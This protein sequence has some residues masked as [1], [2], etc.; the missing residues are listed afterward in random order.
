LIDER[1]KAEGRRRKKDF[2]LH[3]SS[4]ILYKTGDFA[5][6]LPDGTLL[7][8]GRIDDQVKI[9]GVRMELGEVETALRALPG[10]RDAVVTAWRD[11]R[12]DMQL[13]GHIIA[14]TTPAPSAAE[15]RAQLRDRLPEVMIPPYFLFSEAFPLTANGKIRRAALPTPDVIQSDS[16]TPL[17]MPETPSEQLLAQAWARV[18]G[19]ELTRIGRDSDFIDLGGHSLLMTPLMLEVRKLFGVSF[20]LRE[21]F[22]ASTLRAL[23]ALIDERS[24]EMSKDRHDRVRRTSGPNRTPEWGRQRMAFLLREAQLPGSLYPARGMTYQPGEINKVFMTG[25]TGFLGVYLIAEILRTTRAHLYCLARPKRGEDSK[26]RIEKQM[27]RY[28][29]WRKDAPWLA[30]WDTRL[31]VVEGDVTLPRL[32]MADSAYEM[33]A[34]EVDAI[35]HSAAHVNFIYPYEALRATNVLGLHEIIRFAFY[36]RIKP[37]HHLSTAA[38][39]PMGAQYTYYEKDPIDHVG[40]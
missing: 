37:V 16:K 25:G 18:L 11:T 14:A 22:S 29:V 1:M 7:C 20:N 12:G 28:D 36:A 32:G 39:W 3:P 30:D 23:T 2:I 21:F 10:I 17:E 35:L 24:N 33:L 8:L 6:Y 26:S 27:H 13:V 34:R 19:I 9:H 40:V 31:H 4:L 5:R 15:L 38:I